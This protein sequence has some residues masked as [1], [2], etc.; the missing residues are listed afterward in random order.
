MYIKIDF[1]SVH[2]DFDSHSEVKLD[3]IAKQNP[4]DDKLDN[5]CESIS[6]F[7]NLLKSVCFGTLTLNNSSCFLKSC[8][9][10]SC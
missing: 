8:L 2:S 5:G 4:K 6:H 1:D 3:T 10:P 9:S 7:L